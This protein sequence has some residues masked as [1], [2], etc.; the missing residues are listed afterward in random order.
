VKRPFEFASDENAGFADERNSEVD[1]ALLPCPVL[2]IHFASEM[3]CF[4]S[5]MPFG[6]DPTNTIA[7]S[8]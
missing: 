7:S 3:C 2:G 5:M 4:D 8:A 1:R 6:I